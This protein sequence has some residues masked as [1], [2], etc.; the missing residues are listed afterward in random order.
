MD[1]YFRY[2]GSFERISLEIRMGR[3]GRKE[4]EDVIRRIELF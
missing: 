1:K 2:E 4:G 3:V